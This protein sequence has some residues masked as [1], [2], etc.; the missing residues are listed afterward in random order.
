MRANTEKTGG[1][2]THLPKGTLPNYPVKIKV[3]QVNFAIKVD[4]GGETTAHISSATWEGRVGGKGW[5]YE[6]IKG[7]EG[8]KER[9]ERL[10]DISK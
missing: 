1:D 5:R 6:R 4:R 7:K 9:K 3:V 2:T 8:D 10:S